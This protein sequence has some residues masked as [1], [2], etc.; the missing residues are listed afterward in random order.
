MAD[1]EE[2]SV[3]VA[4]RMRL[5]NGR[6]KNASA[7]RI[8]RMT[9]ED[10]G[11]KTFI[12]NPDTGEERHFQFDYSFQ[13]HSQD[14]PGIGEYATQDTVFNVL[15]KPVLYTAL[16]GRNVCLFAYGQTGAGKS[17][18][19][20]G[21]ADPKELQGIIPRSC[22][23]I[24]RL[25][26]TERDDPCIKYEVS[27]QVVEIYCEMVNDL[28][29]D[30]KT[31]PP[32]GH[33]P[34]LTKDGYVCDTVTRPCGN[35]Q[36]IE[37]AFTFADKNRSVGSHALNPESSRAHTIYCIN[38]LRQKKTSPDAK[39]AETITAKINL[40]DLAGS[41]RSES[42]GT[43]GQMLKEGNAINLSLTALGGTI[44]ALSEGKRPNFRDSKLT[45]LLQGSMTNGKVIMIAAVSPASI[46]YDES[47]STLRFAERIKMVKIKAKK[48]VTQDPV[49]EIK[50]EMEEMRQR[51]Q[52]EIDLLKAQTE[53]KALPKSEK[54]KELESLLAAQ[55]AAEQELRDDMEKQLAMYSKSDAERAADRDAAKAE[56]DAQ[57]ETALGGAALQ[58]ADDIKE[59]H[60]RNL[61]ED[62]RLAETLLYAFKEGETKIGRS[63]KED[64]PDIE[65][66]GMG[67]IRGHCTAMWDK[68]GGR[69]WLV[70]AVGSSTMVNGKKVSE[71]LELVH[72]NR[73]WLGNNYAFRFVFPGRE[74]AGEKFDQPVEYMMAAGEVAEHNSITGSGE[75]G[76]SAELRHQLSE[77]LKKVE[78]A[79]IIASDLAKECV[80]EPKIVKDQT[81]HDDHVVVNVTLPRGNLLWPWEKFNTRLVDMV[82]L[83]Q[84]WQHAQD[85]DIK[86]EEPAPEQNPFVDLED[87]L[88]G[89]AN[90]WLKSLGNMIE[91]SADLK[92][93]TAVG[94]TEGKL[95]V[96]VNPLDKNGDEGPWEGDREDLDPL[97][98]APA[99]LLDT[100]IGFVVKVKKLQFDVDI[101]DG[102]G[103]AKFDNVWVRYK[104][105]VSDH[106]EQWKQSDPSSQGTLTPEFNYSQ[107]EKRVVDKS[108]LQH[109]EKGRIFFQVW[110][111]LSD[112]ARRP[113]TATDG[114]NVR[115]RQQEERQTA[116]RDLNATIAL[117]RQGLPSLPP[118]WEAVAVYRHPDGGLHSHP[119]G[120]QGGGD[121]EIAD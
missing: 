117:L 75:T 42:A 115:K 28:L 68:E 79:N 38:Y 60:L 69:V 87:Q 101:S 52:E 88:I 30:R 13:S 7:T 45:L 64:P 80:F 54:A 27:I 63:N 25:R 108:F 77:A 76:K 92:V 48:N 22:L 96:E 70:P 103:H 73:L 19:M 112:T 6:E 107:K 94:G 14:E 11:S 17:F 120:G 55:Q 105:D 41:E 37:S 66:N 26:D 118:G 39:Q 91:H 56:I 31:W 2:E 57:W 89:E 67:I 35:Y 61:N 100:E 82:R 90:L 78:Q 46:C 3:K 102:T 110:G 47:M 65:F 106:E 62:P 18:S 15:G 121:E 20:L 23:E 113:T 50:K 116:L 86:F 98:E 34:R 72:N 71:K 119:P 84:Q 95:Y 109:I 74:D 53:G 29:A 58:K 32:N 114:R 33:K 93:F 43:T 104:I 10:R 24:F 81:T 1:G 85:N 59:P 51:M 16:E 36:D 4:V 99:Q 40:V 49:A 44:K 9:Q 111:K 97:V 5:F 8:V 83:W 21:K 12:T